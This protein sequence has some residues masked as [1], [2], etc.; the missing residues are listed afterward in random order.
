MPR[1]P[2]KVIDASG[3]VNA[4]ETRWLSIWAVQG[5]AR[6]GGRSR[7]PIRSRPPPSHLD[8][9]G[10][11]GAAGEQ[12][13]RMT[14]RTTPVQRRAPEARARGGP[15][16]A[17]RAWAVA[18]AGALALCLPSPGPAQTV[19]GIRTAVTDPAVAAASEART[20]RM[21]LQAIA[22]EAAA[23]V[24]KRKHLASEIRRLKID[25]DNIQA[26]LVRAGEQ[27]RALNR[28]IDNGEQ[29]LQDLLQT[30]AGL[31][32][33]LDARRAELAD[34]LAT[35]QRIGRHPPPAIVA[36]PS[37]AL[38]SIR[39]AILLGAVMP[40]IRSQ[41]ED[42]QRD[43]AALA[44]LKRQIDRERAALQADAAAFAQENARLELLLAEKADL[45]TNS[46]QALAAERER[47]TELAARAES[48]KELIAGTEPERTAAASAAPA[49]D[50]RPPAG[51]FQ[52]VPFTA[53]TGKL[54]LPADGVI[55]RRFGEADSLGEKS[56]GLSMRVSPHNRIYSPVDAKVAY[57]GPFRSYGQVLIL[58]A[59]E[60][61][62]IV[63]SGM[64]RIDVR[65]DQFILAGE[66][67]GRMGSTRF[68]SAGTIDIQTSEPVLYIEFRKDGGAIDPSP[69]WAT[70][71][72]EKVGG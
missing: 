32:A 66:P 57:A 39:S 71:R 69:W 40:Q 50:S 19:E 14:D 21:E 23:N 28:A 51:L 15:P 10:R 46:E 11:G 41:T 48:L 67:V 7:E 33:R 60:G 42:L 38:A 25:Q 56:D 53:S 47:A 9:T 1:G 68:A 34:I 31:Q 12:E 4:S 43:L 29:R 30:E 70:S 54:P 59:G 63:L 55:V 64:D 18:A 27:I 20:Y 44:G 13:C 26:A 72:A 8:P 17:V 61:Y 36:Q 52:S 49:P 37:D 58:D 22:A 65:R 6:G 16:A 35:L 45:G 3:L 24:E 62:H 5:Y 2:A